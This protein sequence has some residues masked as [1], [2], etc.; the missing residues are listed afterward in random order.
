MK[1]DDMVISNDLNGN[2]TGIYDQIIPG[3]EWFSCWMCVTYIASTCQLYDFG[4]VG[5][6]GHLKIA[7]PFIWAKG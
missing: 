7:T 1:W 4:I 5:K 3:T 2:M 6:G